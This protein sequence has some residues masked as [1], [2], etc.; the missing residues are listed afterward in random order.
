MT[1]ICSYL[2]LNL[3]CRHDDL[4]WQQRKQAWLVLDKTPNKKHIDVW[5][6]IYNAF[7]DFSV[8]KRNKISSVIVV[9]LSYFCTKETYKYY[10]RVA[11]DMWRRDRK[12]N[13]T[14][15]LTCLIYAVTNP[16]GGYQMVSQTGYFKMEMLVSSQNFRSG[17]E[18]DSQVWPQILLSTSFIHSLILPLTIKD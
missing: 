1:I 12:Y 17:S 18:F 9:F 13:F 2:G 15:S 7:K 3:L 14:I 4:G 6:S 11:E 8:V 16:R 5:K 10:W